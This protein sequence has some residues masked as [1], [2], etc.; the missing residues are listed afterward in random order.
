ML[1]PLQRAAFIASK[2][3]STVSSA[4]FWVSWR[5]ATRMAIRSL[6]S[7]VA[8]RAVS[9]SRKK[10]R[11]MRTLLY[12]PGLGQAPKSKTCK[13]IPAHLRLPRPDWGQRRRCRLQDGSIVKALEEGI[14]RLAQ[15]RFGG[16]FRLGERSRDR[17]GERIGFLRGKAQCRS[18]RGAHLRKRDGGRVAARQPAALFRLDGEARVGESAQALPDHAAR[19]VQLGAERAESKR[20]LP[21]E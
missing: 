16:A 9:A 1:S 14:Q 4:C 12:L 10:L 19:G 21:R 15:H 8:L 5:F 11:R 6:F 20:S 18:C 13:R 2:I 3:V 17:L 7:I